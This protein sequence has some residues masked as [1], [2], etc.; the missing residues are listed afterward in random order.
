[1]NV[2][3]ICNGNVCRSPLAQALL[4]KKYKLNKIKSKISSAGFESYN[5]NEPPHPRAVEFGEQHGLV[6]DHKARLFLKSDFK[7]FDKIYVMDTKNY[8]DVKDLAQNKSEIA[9]I[10][11][12]MN[13]LEPGTNK[14]VPDPFES[15][16]YNF[17]DVYNLL[18]KATDRIVEMAKKN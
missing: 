11:Y 16:I 14:T 3:F 12:L 17:I 1:M 18:D 8:R 10:D 6:M 7:D 5:I 4:K 15:G 13:A 9:K 2:L